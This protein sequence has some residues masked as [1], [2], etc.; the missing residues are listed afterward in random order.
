M[1]IVT[2]K[3]HLFERE[4]ARVMVDGAVAHP[5]ADSELCNRYPPNDRPALTAHITAQ[6]TPV[7]DFWPESSYTMTTRQ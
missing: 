6:A 3:V 2:P 1:V 4:R 5:A 7:F